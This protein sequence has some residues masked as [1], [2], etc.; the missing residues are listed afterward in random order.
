MIENKTLRDKYKST[1]RIYPKINMGSLTPEVK[2]YIESQGVQ[3]DDNTTSS[4]KVWSSQKTED[5]IKALLDKGIYVTSVEPTYLEP[6]DI[7]PSL[8][9]TDISNKLSTISINAED[10]IIYIDSSYK[11]KTIYK[12]VGL[13]GAYLVLESIASFGGGS[14]LYQHNLTITVSA[15]SYV[16]LQILNKSNTPIDYNALKTFLSNYGSL[17]IANGQIWSRAYNIIAVYHSSDK[18]YYRYLDGTSEANSEIEAN[19]TIQDTIIEL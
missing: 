4:S 2:A 3:I 1:K 16:R 12:V 13:G 6:T 10:L 9:I 15:S 19:D 11:A 18:I 17:Y 5:R 8:L 14:Q 7:Y